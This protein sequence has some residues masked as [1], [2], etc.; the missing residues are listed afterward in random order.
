MI[1]GEKYG[2][3]AKNFKKWTKTTFFSSN[4][5]CSHNLFP[6]MEIAGFTFHIPRSDFNDNHHAEFFIGLFK[7]V[8]HNQNTL[9]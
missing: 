9:I 1:C 3:C 7:A 8:I 2:F 5:N 4:F 6:N